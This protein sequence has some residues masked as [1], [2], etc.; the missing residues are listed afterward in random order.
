MSSSTNN[1]DSSLL[2]KALKIK[3][4]IHFFWGQE[5]KL[6]CTKKVFE[7]R[8]TEKSCVYYIFSWTFEKALWCQ[9]VY[10]IGRI[11]F[12]ATFKQWNCT[13]NFPKNSCFKALNLNVGKRGRN[14]R[15]DFLPWYTI[16]ILWHLIT[17]NLSISS[18]TSTGSV[19]RMKAKDLHS[20]GCKKTFCLK[21]EFYWLSFAAY[22]GEKFVQ[23]FDNC[24]ISGHFSISWE[25]INFFDFLTVI[26]S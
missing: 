2:L 20:G 15:G 19:L 10:I 24:L 5:S 9:L 13:W 22:W 26:L 12:G 3:F 1:T 11:T 17:D 18:I 6:V 16:I 7:V 23:N 4:V 14:N 21:E 25:C 8:K